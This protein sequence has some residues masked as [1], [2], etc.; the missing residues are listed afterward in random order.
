ML[1]TER[2][3][4]Y[5]DTPHKVHPDKFHYDAHL[6]VDWLVQLGLARPGDQ[7]HLYLDEIDQTKFTI[8]EFDFD[9][10]EIKRLGNAQ[11]ELIDLIK[12]REYL[13]NE[14]PVGY[15]QQLKKV[16]SGKI[17]RNKAVDDPA[18]NF[19]FELSLASRFL[20]AGM[21]IKLNDVA[22][23][24]IYLGTEVIFVE[25]KRVKSQKQ[26]ERRISEANKQ[27]TK[28]IKN[29]SRF[30]SFGLAAVDVTDLIN[31]DNE[32]PSSLSPVTINSNNLDRLERFTSKYQNKI[33]R[34]T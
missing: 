18:R 2:G 20:A 10:P 34:N 8:H 4:N 31:P 23:A 6:S 3:Q 19:L 16:A 32:M 22:D 33:Y 25:A 28:R 27:I 15:L 9:S 24:E 1:M 17:L 12:I 21:N 5:F 29:H 11:N 14:N 26:L 13:M 30:S 7:Y